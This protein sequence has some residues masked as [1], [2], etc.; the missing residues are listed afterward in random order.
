MEYMTKIS[1]CRKL[2]IS[3][4][5]LELLIKEGIF[6]VEK[7]GGLPFIEASQLSRVSVEP[8]KHNHKVRVI[9]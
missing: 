3:R 2:K 1:A 4:P 5:T 6:K 9:S 7:I 8:D